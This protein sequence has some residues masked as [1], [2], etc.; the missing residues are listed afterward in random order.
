MSDNKDV[1]IETAVV[2]GDTGE[3]L[4][5]PE[6]LTILALLEQMKK[7]NRPYESQHYPVAMNNERFIHGKQIV[8]RRDDDPHVVDESLSWPSWLPPITRNMM[9]NLSLTKRSQMI[10]DTP[11]TKA[12]PGE[13][14]PTDPAATQVA[15][16]VLAYLKHKFDWPNMLAQ[17]SAY[18]EAHGVVGFRQVWEPTA[19]ARSVDGEPL[20]DII[21]EPVTCFDFGMSAASVED[22][23]WLFF[24][25]W[26][27]RERARSML[28]DAGI[29][30]QPD[31]SER[32]TVWANEREECVEAYEIWYLPTSHRIPRGLHAIVVGGHVTMHEDYPYEHNEL[33]FGTWYCDEKSGWPYGD[34]HVTD[35]CP[36]QANINRL[37]AAKTAVL[38]RTAQWMKLLVPQSIV[39]DING[40]Q[41]VIGVPTGFD[42]SQIKVITV[43]DAPTQALD[44]Q[45]GK[46]EQKL[47]DVYGINEAVL[48]SD[49]SATKNARHLAYVS[50]LDQQKNAITRRSLNA[51][52]VRMDQQALRLIQQFVTDERLAR[53]VGEDGMQR[54]VAFRGADVAGIDVILEPAPGSDQTRAAKAKEAEELAA[55]QL[56]DPTAAAERRMTGLD[57]TLAE[58]DAA[59]VVLQQVQEAI[60]G[61][62]P[63][64]DS[65]VALPI[66]ERV[67]LLALDQ[68]D[69]DP[70]AL[71]E[72]L[73]AYREIAAQAAQAPAQGQVKPVGGEST[74]ADALP[75]V[76]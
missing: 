60:A 39:N 54:I 50:E 61:A 65:R 57:E 24:R 70:S 48:G 59:R 56:L 66:A 43:D 52:N 36:V 64:P 37:E 74:S 32:D 38:A 31:V 5:E 75:E 62:M 30:E 1:D 34:T 35:A 69:G 12:W 4:H 6:K 51:C 27:T 13:S 44:A 3:P 45:I 14:G 23:E 16:H 41:Q 17:A 9:R 29:T 22:S 11:S 42:M 71:L 21:R 63:E 68:L 10:K 15:D 20:G 25:R 26:Y 76:Q 19:G 7:A 49:A 73:D 28:L 72:L 2:L 46:E 40:S 67:I 47:M 55:A 18:C 8:G 58:N 53:I 33:P